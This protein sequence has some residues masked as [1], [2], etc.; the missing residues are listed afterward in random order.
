MKRS[1]L[2]LAVG[3]ACSGLAAEPR[4]TQ[5]DFGGVGLLQTPTA[6][7]SPAGE[8][9]VNANRTAPYSRYSLTLQPFDWLEGTFRYT[10][11]SNRR[12][13]PES[14]SGDQ[15]YK[16]KAFD[17]KLRLWQEDR[18]RP[19]VAFGGRDIGG[20]GL[21][22]SEYVVAN[23][24]FGDFDFSLGLAWGYLGNRGDFDNPL[25][26][27]GDRFDERPKPTSDVANA[28]EFKA[29]SYFRGSP[30]L[31][32]GLLWQ[33]PWEPLQLK[34]EYE[35]NDYQNE[36]QNNDQV[37]D[38]PVNLG[39]VFKASDWVDLHA[40]WERGNTAMFGI[41]LHTNFVSRTAPA[42][43][44]DPQ[45]EPLR[46]DRERPDIQADWQAVGARLNDNAGLRVTKIAERERELVVY[47]EQTRYFSSAKGLGR[48]ARIVDNS[49]AADID[50]ITLVESR[51]G[52]PV[53]ETSLKRDTFRDLVNEETDLESLRRV[54]EQ[55]A[56]MA[57]SETTL[58]S[59]EPKK[60]TYGAGLGYRQNIGGP[61]NFLL[62]QFSLNASAEY[63][64]TQA[65]RLSGTLSASLL[66]NLDE[67]KY[68]APSNLP[69]VRTYLREY[70][71][72]TDV[73]MPTLNLSHA[74]RLDR[75]LY[76][77]LYAG[78]LESMFAGTG[79]EL[80]YRPMNERWA[81]GMDLNWVQ[82]RG[83]KQDFSLRDYKTLTGHVTGYYRT[84]GDVLFA[85]SVGRY[86]AG[87]LG[88]TVDVSREFR[89]GVRFGAWATI[90]DTMG[91][92][93]G[94]GSFDKGIYLSVPFDELLTT[95]TLQRAN[96]V[97]GPLT[98]DGGAR[99]GR[100]A[101]LYYLTD[102][103]DGDQFHYNFHKVAE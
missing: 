99:V 102:G 57:R 27:L 84:P 74:R 89:N 96:L 79:G 30:S 48:T 10:V 15:S 45:P 68:T 53:T 90:T 24:R 41:T 9:S 16:D 81:L 44:S 1:L 62:Y 35:G 76:G 31:F 5:S 69:R 60:L 3:A 100:P 72:S 75:D 8:F 58:Y 25:G 51:Y 39:L 18:W 19:E 37:Q 4:Y 47:G 46:S 14:F 40:A 29:N 21:F 59:P 12:Y 78:Y 23:K 80:L 77:L 64:F 38:S 50:W 63:R 101:A 28:G 6:R 55:S 52:I 22:S 66:D 97:W 94:E 7:M 82:Q 88:F 13:G 11:V 2:A 87:D 70:W 34:L 85:T 32:G 36:P 54:T 95:S 33:T 73:A 20:T 93:Y 91:D 103:R 98:R 43:V 71:T 65:T 67:F 17:A 92:Q 61:D 49:A 26:L 86:L 42:K 83:F 56:P